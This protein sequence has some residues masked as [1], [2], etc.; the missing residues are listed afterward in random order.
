MAVARIL[1]GFLACGATALALGVTALRMLRIELRRAEAICLGYAVG[2]ALTSTLTLGIAVLWQAREGVFLAIAGGALILLWRQ[3][4]W[5]RGLAP[6][7]L[8]SIPMALRLIFA[9]AWLAYG[10]IYFRQALSPEMSPDG[11]AYHLGL[12]NLWDHAHGLIRNN[13]MY[14]ALPEGVEMLFLFAFA[15]GRHSAAALV[16][17]SFL[18]CLP[19]L[20]I[21]YGCRFGWPRGG[22]VVAAL[23][24]FASPLV[25]ADGTAAYNDVALAA[26]VFA[27]V[28]LLEMWRHQRTMGTLLAASLLAGFAFAVKYT[29]GP[30][31]LFFAGTIVWERRRAPR[32]Q[33]AKALL[34]ALAVM[35]L[36]PAPYLIR[37]AIWFQNPIAFFGNSIF[38]NRWF[39]VSAERE[40]RENVSHW[41]GVT[42]SDMP[43]ELTWGGPKTGESFG[44]AFAIL[45]LALIGVAWPQ[46]RLLLMAG[47]ISACALAGDKSGRFLIPAVPLLAMAAAYALCRFRW[48][49][50]LAGAIAVAHLAVSWPTVSNRLHIDSGWRLMH[51]PWRVALRLQPEDEYLRKDDRYTAAR[52]I[53]ER[54][55][56]GQPV[57][58]F[59]SGAVGQ[60]YT[61]RPILVAW[62]SALGETVRDWIGDARNSADFPRRRWTA[63]FSRTKVRELVVTQAG[64]TAGQGIWSINEIRLWDRD[65]LWR[66]APG[67]RLD[68]FPYPWDI[69]LA[70]DGS[71]ATRWRSWERLRPGMWVGVRLDRPEE[72][73]HVEVLC[74]DGQWETRMTALALTSEGQWKGAEV[75]G[76]H[77]DPPADL[78][79]EAMAAIK[80]LGVRY[81]AV[82]PQRWTGEPFRG[83]LQG[84]GV[85]EVGSTPGLVLVEAE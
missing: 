38:R 67:W 18:M 12:V 29:A 1:I 4:E 55:P 61:T 5:L 45:P 16:H 69:G 57:F 85:R 40:Y 27:A 50:W 15:I 37:N 2:S 24:V 39:H 3:R 64:S 51:I 47:A 36:T 7:R 82:G 58:V 33:A 43:R 17:F 26:V 52:L 74:N 72:I 14:A 48:T 19:L 34:A 46:T 8:D 81:F 10:V 63:S 41:H 80:R 76:W 11:M 42:W 78:R 25:A 35:A 30:L 77:M 84:W 56:E 9:A 6:A 21:L 32:R 49:A 73:D 54:V 20:T 44:P 23:L 59:A 83:D 53:E 65:R 13:G 22:A 66:R 71:E 62:E 28:Y 31:L 75:T 79:R 68:A 60:S 70:F